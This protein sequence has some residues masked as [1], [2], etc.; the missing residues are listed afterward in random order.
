MRIN[1]KTE[2]VCILN[3]YKACLTDFLAET[4]SEFISDCTLGNLANVCQ[5]EHFLKTRRRL[6][7]HPVY[8]C[9]IR[10]KNFCFCMS[11]S[12]LLFLR[13][14]RKVL[15]INVNPII[16]FFQT[17]NSSVLSSTVRLTK[18]YSSSVLLGITRSIGSVT[19]LS[20][21]SDSRLRLYAERFHF[22]FYTYATQILGRLSLKAE[23]MRKRAN[24][25]KSKWQ[26][27]MVALKLSKSLCYKS[28]CFVFVTFDPFCG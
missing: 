3:H 6:V 4:P 25:R 12:N 15:K 13:N 19:R 22:T 16:S 7:D 21:L 24:V 28:V 23:F 8:V 11:T 26:H 18:R 2:W 17:I 20:H 27:K 14:L 5:N 9:N 10:M 1:P